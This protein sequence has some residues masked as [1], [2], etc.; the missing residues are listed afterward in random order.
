MT[1]QQLQ[2]LKYPI[3]EFKAPETITAN[4]IEQW[5][6]D[7]EQ[8]PHRIKT[9][10]KDLSTEQL[11]WRYRPEGWNIKQVVHH[12]A[13]S[14]V[15]SI[16][17]FKLALTEDTPTIRPYFEDRWAT[18]ID[19]NDDDLGDTLN[20][21]TGLHAKLGKLLRNMTDEDMKR[22]FIHPEHSKKFTLDE[23]IGVYAW[24]GNH[25]LAHVKQAI[26]YKGNFE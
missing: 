15:N 23:N 19:C 10:T 25:H 2:Q 4:H 18:L 9:I 21:L 14:H 1:P 7:I 16:I 5:I 17:R 8:F 26:Q 24:H 13:D 11:N 3:G 22:E 12:C 20:L 6:T